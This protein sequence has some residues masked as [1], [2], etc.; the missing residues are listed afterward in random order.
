LRTSRKLRLQR[1]VR[2]FGVE[3]LLRFERIVWLLGI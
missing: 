3:R 1:I 2:L